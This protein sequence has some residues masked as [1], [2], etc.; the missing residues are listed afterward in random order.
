MILIWS[1]RDDKTADWFIG[2]YLSSTNVAWFRF[3]TDTFPE[4]YRIRGT[5]D[6]VVVHGCDGHG[7]F[8]PKEISSVWYRREAPS[9]FSNTPMSPEALE[10]SRSEAQT[11][12]ISIRET[13]N[14]VRWVNRPEENRAASDKLSQLRDARSKGFR[15]PRTLVTN[16]SSSAVE[17]AKECGG[18]VIVKALRR[19]TIEVG[20][21]FYST[22]MDIASL[23][24]HT[25]S[26]AVAPL[27]FQ[28]PIR[29]DFE[30]RAT[31]VDDMCF[32]VKIFSQER[33]ITSVDWRRN[34]L[35]LRHEIV[36]LPTE[37]VERCV[38]I[39]RSC[40]LLFSAFDLIVTPEGEYVF[41]EHNPAG[42]FAWLE[43]LTGIPIGRKLLETLSQDS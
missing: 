38:A 43:E 33:E 13:L 39:T 34:P 10:Y 15:V 7:S 6:E 8:N 20:R 19:G 2:R 32:G 42:Q 25:E 28:E 41:L 14:H 16:D 3:D 17:F 26:I 1:C 23:G 5:M 30:V 12:L 21:V 37:V 27:I 40:R 36:D 9:V 31:V 4:M 11:M 18:N 35:S 22:L 24:K 29:K